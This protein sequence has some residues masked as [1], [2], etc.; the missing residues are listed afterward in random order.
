MFVVTSMALQVC[1][2]SEQWNVLA[3]VTGMVRDH[4]FISEKK[5]IWCIFPKDLFFLILPLST[6]QVSHCSVV[7]V[8]PYPALS[9]WSANTTKLFSVQV[10]ISY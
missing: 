6:K 7:I 4:S 5:K 3:V 2:N 1:I 9:D 10:T 8:L